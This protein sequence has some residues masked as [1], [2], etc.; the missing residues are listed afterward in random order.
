MFASFLVFLVGATVSSEGAIAL[1]SWEVA[2][3]NSTLTT[4]WSSILTM[5]MQ[6][7]QPIAILSV[8]IILITFVLSKLGHR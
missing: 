6:F 5:F 3:V 7:R 8:T 2:S 4:I 1:S